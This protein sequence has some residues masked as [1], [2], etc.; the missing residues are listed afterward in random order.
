MRI[1]EINK[2]SNNNHKRSKVNIK[3][4][5]QLVF[6]NENQV[7][8]NQLRKILVNNGVHDE[9]VTINHISLADIEIEDN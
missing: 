1:R 4:A 6:N 5:I 7:V 3:C 2:T 9:A 8:I